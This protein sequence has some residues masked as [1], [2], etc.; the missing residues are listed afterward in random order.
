MLSIRIAGAC[1]I[2][3]GC[4]GIGIW[5]KNRLTGRIKALRMLQTLLSLL[6]SEIS[7]SRETLPEACGHLSGRIQGDVGKALGMTAAEMKENTGESFGDIFQRYLKSVF[8][9][10]PL[11]DED[12]EDFFLFV[13]DNGYADEMMQRRL[14]QQSCEL[15]KKK[16]DVLSRDNAEKCRMA[17]GLGVM[18]GMLLLLVLS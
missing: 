7:Y 1:M 4:T 10:L 9:N 8:S 6:E 18:G 14:L 12:V 11:K 5:Y 16:T 15:L 13:S 3:M 2:L 17:L